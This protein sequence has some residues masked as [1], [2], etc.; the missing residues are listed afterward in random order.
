MIKSETIKNK[1]FAFSLPNCE[2]W[3]PKAK[4]SK[5]FIIYY[6]K[7]EGGSLSNLALLVSVSFFYCFP[8]ITKKLLMDF[9]K[10][11]VHTKE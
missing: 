10:K 3:F 8:F 4:N 6:I 7:K 11:T 2:I 1:L 5:V 9:Y